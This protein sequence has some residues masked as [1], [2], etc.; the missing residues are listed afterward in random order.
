MQNSSIDPIFERNLSLEAVRVTE[1][2]ALRTLNWIGRGEKDQADQ[3]AVSAMRQVLS[4]LSIDGRIVIGEGERDEAPM[5][6]VGEKV[7]IGGEQVD[8]AVDPLEG[9]DLCAHDGP[10]AMAVIAFAER[11]GLLHAPDVYMQ[12]IAYRSKDNRPIAGVSVVEAPEDNMRR[13]AQHWGQEPHELHV[14]MLDRPRH[15]SILQAARALGCRVT[16]IPDGDISAVI[17]TIDPNSSI[18]CYIG[19]GGAPEGVL[20][21]AAINCLGGIIEGKLVFRNEQE[22]QRARKTGI[23]DLERI[24]LL[25]DLARGKTTFTATGITSGPLLD[26]MELTATG[27]KTHSVAMRSHTHTIRYITAHHMLSKLDTGDA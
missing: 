8:I 7:G 14:C 4:R 17:A 3:A 22:I 6:F 20:A 10:G 19:T 21:A 12:K 18:N 25:A 15:A 27:V 24:Y 5:L 1:A 13:I 2:A 16:L 26:G 9:T 23:D 11:E